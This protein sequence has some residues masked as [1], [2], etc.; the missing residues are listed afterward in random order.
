[1]I[2]P[3]NWITLASSPTPLAPGQSEQVQVALTPAEDQ[4]LGRFNGD[5]AV[6]YGSTGVP[7]PF[8]IDVVSDQ[9]GSVQVVVDDESTTATEAGGAPRRA[10]SCS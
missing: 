1:M 9:H 7:V 4:P 8:T 5:L 10:P 3:V 6:D 2:S